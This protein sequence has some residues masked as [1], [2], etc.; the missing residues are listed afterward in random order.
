MITDY[1]R[2]FE[3]I[4]TCPHCKTEL[5]CCESPAIHVGD[6]LGWGS[7]VLYIC[8]NDE[9]SVFINGWK[10]IEIQ[11]GHSSSYRYMQLPGSSES[12][13][14]M[15]GS[16]DAFKGSI[17]DLEVVEAQNIRYQNE[18]KALEDLESSAKEKDLGP[19]MQLILDE[20]AGVKGRK[21][22]IPL[23]LEINDLGCID[24]IRNH[25]FRDTSVESECNMIIPQILKANFKKECPFCLE[26]V[27]SKARVCMHC[28]KEL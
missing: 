17:I 11:Y 18:K 6:G 20:A 27:K 9:C 16:E 4:P 24:P 26:L 2:Y 13:V 15:V 23:L 5:S 25:K 1:K 10:Q 14:M 12:N 28:K 3:N 21:K 8:L 22:A 7:D 19:A